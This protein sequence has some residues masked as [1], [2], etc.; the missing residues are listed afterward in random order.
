THRFDTNYDDVD[1]VA[2]S[3]FEELGGQR[4]AGRGSGRN[5]LEWPAG[6]FADHRGEGRLVVTP[7][8]GAAPIT[9]AAFET[10]R[11]ARA[12]PRGAD[13]REWGPFAIIPLPR[14]LP[15]A[16]ELTYR[17][18]PDRI[19]VGPSRFATERTHVAFQGATAWGER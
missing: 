2:F 17:F 14:H 9:A 15:I 1:L 16:G 6:R 11:P 3:D 4:V 19:E 12:S 10:V 18:D 8:S 13:A 7:P 5:V